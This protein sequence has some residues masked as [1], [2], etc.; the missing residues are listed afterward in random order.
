MILSSFYTR[1]ELAPRIA[2]MYSGNSLANGWGSSESRSATSTEYTFSFLSFSRFGGLLASAIISGLE[3]R[4][5]IA[6]WRWLCRP[7]RAVNFGQTTA[8]SQFSAAV[9]IEGTIT[10]L[11]GMCCYFLLPS[12]PSKTVWLSEEQRRLAIWRSTIDASGSEDEADD[13]S[14]TQAVKLI[15]KDWKVPHFRTAPCHLLMATSSLQVLLLI[16]QQ[17]FIACSQVRWTRPQN[18]FN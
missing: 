10:S 1:R 4:A 16:L 8:D 3:G 11:V 2:L 5:G 7:R 9:I 15:F 6:G 14:R 12:V 13:M 18:A 17:T